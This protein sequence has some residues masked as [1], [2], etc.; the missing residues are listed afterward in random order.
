MK[1]NMTLERYDV[2]SL[3]EVYETTKRLRK[4]CGTLKAVAEFL[5]SKLAS[6]NEEFDSSNYVRV[7]EASEDFVKKMNLMEQE[8]LELGESCYQLAEKLNELWS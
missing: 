5:K 6:A 2:K 4:R 3:D 7:N 8:L 1:I